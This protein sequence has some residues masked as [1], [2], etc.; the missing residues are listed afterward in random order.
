MKYL[1]QIKCSYMKYTKSFL[2]TNFILICASFKIIHSCLMVANSISFARRISS[3]SFR[4]E[5]SVTHETGLPL[6]ASHFCTISLTIEIISP[7]L[8]FFDNTHL[9]SII[10]I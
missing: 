9:C 4:T 2:I 6:P 8:F 7:L 10:I 3:I 1:I 5:I